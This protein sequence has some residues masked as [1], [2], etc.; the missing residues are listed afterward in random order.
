MEPKIPAR[1]IDVDAAGSLAENTV[2]CPHTKCSGLAKRT[3]LSSGSAGPTQDSGPSL[4]SHSSLLGV[5][6]LIPT[7]LTA[8]DDPSLTNAILPK[9]EAD[10]QTFQE[11]F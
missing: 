11:T 5:T 1:I 2:R 9:A 4:P 7:Q 10:F 6:K 8:M 3:E